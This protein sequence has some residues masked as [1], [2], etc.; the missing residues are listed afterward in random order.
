MKRRAGRGAAAWIALLVVCATLHL[1]SSAAGREHPEDHPLV[2][3]LLEDL[4][5][6][7]DPDSVRLL[8][9]IA[10]RNTGTLEGRQRALDLFK[11]V[12]PRYYD[13]PRYHVEIAKTEMAGKRFGDAR[14]SLRRAIARDPDN[15]QTYVVCG[16]LLLPE[17]IR[18]GDD[19]IAR[20][21]IDLLN[22]GLARDPKHRNIL[23]LKSLFL[24][25]SR[26]LAAGEQTARSLAGRAATE[27]ILAEDDRD[28]SAYMLNGIHCVDLNDVEEADRSFRAGLSYMVDSV[29]VAYYLP[30]LSA[31]DSTLTRLAG[32]PDARMPEGIGA[33][34]SA[35]DPTP[36]TP[37][38]ESLLEYWRRMALADF[39][40][41]DVE[42]GTHGW[43]TPRG[44]VMVRYGPPAS[45][46][47]ANAGFANA[48]GE[49]ATDI[50]LALRI[51]K[52]PSSLSLEFQCPTQ[53]WHY[54]FP[55][56][57]LDIPFVDATLHDRFIPAQPG[58]LRQTTAA[59]P[60]IPS[61]SYGGDVKQCFISTAGFRDRDATRQSIYVGLPRWA[62][63]PDWWAKA[64]YRVSLVGGE[65]GRS[66]LEFGP[67]DASMIVHPSTETEMAVVSASA[68]LK[69]GR[70][71][72]DFAVESE[73]KQGSFT[74][75][76]DVRVFG[77]D[78]LEISDLRLVMPDDR[79]PNPSGALVSDAPGEVQFEIYNLTPGADGVAHYRTRYALLPREYVVEFARLA[80]AG[81][82]GFDPALRLGRPGQSLG[83]VTL[84]QENYRDVA[85]PSNTV[86]IA[87]GGRGSS[88]IRV[89]TGGI[90]TGLYALVVSVTDEGSGSAAWAQ[91]PVRI[92]ER[93][94]L[95]RF[96]DGR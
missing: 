81:A 3:Q 54:S 42:S 45:I 77:S 94:E 52:L 28:V 80:A 32:L 95:A 1:A 57:E 30:M 39:E 10:Y 18:Y 73:G 22:E 33:Y 25:I 6:T 67:L 60:S 11:Q 65:S 61:A 37:I 50:G 12:R 86:R 56:L 72:V 79:T 64:S 78:S 26:N 58:I 92:L 83:G 49:I 62:D 27:A 41:G 35:L 13:E 63:E 59:L 14:Q 31:P 34:W 93:A 19:G 5:S 70:Y 84:G 24:A 51:A 48:S 71:I 44:E 43:A 90:A 46:A 7:S 4:K 21:A 23:F 55:G 20:E 36:L 87:P 82:D 16:S 38:N 53:N 68:A 89:E 40:F 88:S 69:P 96:L 91:I 8:L 17:L 85:F 66:T 76:V 15:L 29:R 9:A 47:F 74:L 75:P 2:R